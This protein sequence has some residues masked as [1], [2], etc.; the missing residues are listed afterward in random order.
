MTDFTET[1]ANPSFQALAR[2]LLH[3]LWQGVAVALGLAAL[4]AILA[5]RPARARYAA[6]CL[7]LATMLLAPVVT[8]LVI[9]ARDASP[10]SVAAADAAALPARAFAPGVAA[11]TSDSPADSA[12]SA[13]APSPDTLARLQ[14]WILAA[15]LAGVLV[16]SFRLLLGFAEARWLTRRAVRPAPEE[17]VGS[18]ARLRQR[19]AVSRPV[20]LLASFA[21]EVPTAVGTLSPVILVPASAFT[22]LTAA[23][24]ESIL[25]HE[26]AHIRRADFFV[27]LLQSVVETLLFYHPAVW[28]VSGRIRVERENCCDDLA[29]EAIGNPREYAAAL[30]EMEGLRAPRLAAAA[31]GGKLLER[32]TRLVAPASLPTH[33]AARWLPG[34]LAGAALLLTGA[35]V[36]WP[37]GN[38]SEGFV[39]WHELAE[40]AVPAVTV[41]TGDT[42]LAEREEVEV[43]ATADHAQETAPAPTARPATQASPAP[44]APPAPPDTKASAEKKGKSE[45]SLEDLI[46]L[47]SQGV[48]AGYVREIRALGYDPDAE[49]L[50][51]MKVHGIQPSTI[52]DMN[53]QWGK[54]EIEDLIA[55][56]IHGVTPE[57]AREMKA[58]GAGN[59]DH[60]DLVAMKI[61]GVTPEMFRETRKAYPDASAEDIVAVKIHGVEPG[62]SAQWERLGYPKPDLETLVA[63][64]IHGVTPDFARQLQGLDRKDL[65]DLVA[66]K[67]HG[68]TPEYAREVA[69]AGW[70]ADGEDL[71]SLRIHGVTI[72]DLAAYRELG[73]DSIEDAVGLKIHGIS[74]EKLQRLR[75]S[76]A[77]I[78]DLLEAMEEENR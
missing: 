2:T 66:F 70:K 47:K 1:L 22:G 31:S 50:V 8:F 16:L 55:M 75:K 40:M 20:R 39:V 21:V 33:R 43:A 78:E 35:A 65:D 34:A 13:L 36:R 42:E 14:P 77:D 53:A 76:G 73:V 26:L 28:W 64:R 6:A 67:I 74:A 9:S 58:A 38:T 27:N 29:V 62:D 12:F 51:A 18:L 68:V 32:V 25:A 19:L 48:T 5:R 69:A 71:V 46:A 59:I 54:L 57:F 23:Q 61:H 30:A 24:L 37:A 56:K 60:E 7:A 63:L 52:R 72:K 3:F 45:V 10:A 4:D 11:N 17:A 41:A 49:E 15:W 44:A